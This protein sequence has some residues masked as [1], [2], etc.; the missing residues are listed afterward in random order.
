VLGHEFDRLKNEI[1]AKENEISKK[2]E[3]LCELQRRHKELDAEL[4]VAKENAQQNQDV[5]KHLTESKD[6]LLQKLRQGTA[7]LESMQK[8]KEAFKS[9]VEYIVKND[10]RQRISFVKKVIYLQ[11]KNS[12][13]RQAKERQNSEFEKKNMLFKLNIVHRSLK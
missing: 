12:D 5:I 4:K 6:A 13:L 8:D 10:S 11:T 2:D 3:A 9:T 1:S 7:E